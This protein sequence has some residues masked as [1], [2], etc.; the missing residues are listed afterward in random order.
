N[1]AAW[2]QRTKRK[3]R[4]PKIA[5]TKRPK[6]RG[7]QGQDGDV[8]D[9]AG[10]GV[11]SIELSSRQPDQPSDRPF[12]TEAE[13]HASNEVPNS[14][15][16]TN[17]DESPANE[18]D[19]STDFIHTL[20][21]GSAQMIRRKVHINGILVD[22]L[23]D[24]G[25]TLSL[26]SHSFYQQLCHLKPTQ[27]SDSMFS[28]ITSASGHNV[29]IHGSIEAMLSLPHHSFMHNFHV[30]N[31][32]RVGQNCII[33]LDV[34]KLFKS[35]TFNFEKDQVIL[36]EYASRPMCCA[37]NPTRQTCYHFKVANYKHVEIPPHSCHSVQVSCP[38]LPIEATDVYIEPNYDKLFAHQLGA[39][40]CVQTMDDSKGYVWL[41]N[42]TNYPIPLY[43][44]TT[45]GQAEIF[46][47]GQL[48]TISGVSTPEV[49]EDAPRIQW[50]AEDV[51]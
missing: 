39:I 48:N 12:T 41:V 33:G 27:L 6:E 45:I 25:A 26:I 23:I 17:V 51:L 32:E 34:L 18:E 21:Q 35:V 38:G 5:W 10:D 9:Q 22:T 29:Q 30:A 16:N 19:W 15:E 14:S 36:G 43:E 47:Q 40:S 44:G 7:N 31:M 49:Q 20:G 8:V 46:E 1:P 37:M 11:V 4:L 24:T 42:R 3:F 50:T 2:F 28:K 13:V